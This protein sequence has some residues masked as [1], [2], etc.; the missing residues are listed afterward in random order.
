MQEI[1]NASQ[2]SVNY[3]RK[4][5]LDMLLDP[6]LQNATAETFQIVKKNFRDLFRKIDL[7]YSYEHLMSHL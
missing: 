6:T 2:C 5:P 4:T 1:N 7:T 3:H